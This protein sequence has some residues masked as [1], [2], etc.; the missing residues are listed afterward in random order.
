MSHSTPN[1]NRTYISALGERRTNPL[2][3][4]GMIVAIISKVFYILFR[5]NEVTLQIGTQSLYEKVNAILQIILH[6]LD[7]IQSLFINH[8]LDYSFISSFQKPISSD[9][10]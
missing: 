8:L 6:L 7:V 10:I 2:Y 3:Y 5:N 1:R 9:H 4:R